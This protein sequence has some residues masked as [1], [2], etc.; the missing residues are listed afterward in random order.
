ML[1]WLSPLLALALPYLARRDIVC[2]CDCSGST[3]S[4]VLGI[5][6]EQLAR[7]GPQNLTPLAAESGCLL[8]AFLALLLGA[9]LGALCSWALLRQ[10][11]TEAIGHSALPAAV[12]R[13]RGLALTGPTAPSDGGSEGAEHSPHAGAGRL[14][15]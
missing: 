9:V 1:E 15:R 8:V 5:L 12:S 11:A 13:R 4:A 6:R 14:L 3:D 7:C 10:T 2:S